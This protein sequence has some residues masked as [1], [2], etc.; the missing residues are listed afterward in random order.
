MYK[1]KSILLKDIPE[2]VYKEIQRVQ[3]E[4]KKSYNTQFSLGASIFKIIKSTIKN[5]KDKE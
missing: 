4:H 2:D 3:Y 1:P 5:G